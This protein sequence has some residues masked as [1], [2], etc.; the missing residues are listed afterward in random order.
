[1]S[2][3]RHNLWVGGVFYLVFLVVAYGQVGTGQ[4]T[5]K[6]IRF[7]EYDRKS[8]RVKSLLLGDTAKPQGPGEVLVTGARLETY[9]YR[10]DRR[11]VDL[12]IEA[13]SCLF[14][15]RTR[16]ASS[17]GRMRAYRADQSA[18]V[19][20]TGFEWRQRNSKL[21]IQDQVRT[22]MKFGFTFNKRSEK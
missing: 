11:I 15:F 1:M 14:N 3:N 2:K 12:I 7:P 13:P 19:E 22:E 18:S 20:G 16:V 5:Q 8:G 6:R 21:V 9:T 10:D 17:K 4:G